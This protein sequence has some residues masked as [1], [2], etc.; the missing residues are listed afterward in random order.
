M[1]DNGDFAA[2]MLRTI[3]KYEMILPGMTLLVGVSG[4]QDSVALLHA[5]TQC[6]VTHKCEI[7][8][9]HVNHSFRGEESDGDADYTHDL[10]SKLDVEC[11][12]VKIDVPAMKKRLH[13]S[14]Q[15]A[16]RKARHQALI[17]IAKET[18]SDR[19]L[20]AHTQDDRIET[21]LH[22]IFRGTGLAGLRG[23]PAVAL[24]IIRPLI[25]HSRA[26]T[27]AYCQL[28]ALH[29]RIDSSNTK[30][31]YLR[32]RT[33][34]ELLPYL[35]T[36]YNQ[37]V[38]EALLRLAYI[39]EEESEVLDSY[40]ATLLTAIRV[41]CGDSG[42]II[43]WIKLGSIE[44]PMRRRIIR[45]AIK[46]VRGNLEDISFEITNK[47]ADRPPGN[48]QTSRLLPVSNGQQLVV[49]SNGTEIRFIVIASQYELIPW[50]Y[51]I[52]TPGQTLI[53][54]AGCTVLT[55]IFSSYEA[56]F[57]ASTLLNG[58][59]IFH[60]MDISFPLEVRSWHAGDRIRPYGLNGTKKI[61]DIFTDLK[62]PR[63]QRLKVPIVAEVESG[64]VIMVGA[65]VFSELA[66]K[67]VPSES[68]HD[69]GNSYLLIS[70]KPTSD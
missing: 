46:E 56:A 17:D 35:R 1:N 43:P 38:G 57:E 63:L 21:M 62:V 22:N 28:N 26:D 44:L 5:L 45:T 8:A 68:A 61:Q 51:K 64:R 66:R 41:N 7:I 70:I 23:L 4:G 15:E 12:I 2:I 24:P 60:R 25:E 30:H 18:N 39:A 3:A 34:T 65:H 29:P 31:D 13:L 19:I 14:T 50:N 47:L 49:E 37:G 11:R 9:V 6:R 59:A 20:I 67:S 33:R 42:I 48:R 32:N 54:E 52:N 10:A 58:S 16:A 55:Q 69:I 27:A 36:Y 40:A 53:P